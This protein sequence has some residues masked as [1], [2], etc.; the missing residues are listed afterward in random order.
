MLKSEFAKELQITKARIS[1]LIKEGLPV[2]KDGT[3][4]PEIAASWIAKY[5]SSGRGGHGLRPGAKPDIA[6]RAGEL[7]GKAG[8]AKQSP[9]DFAN[10]LL[11]PKKL[12]TFAKALMTRFN[13]GPREAYIAAELHGREV[14]AA[15]KD[16]D[17]YG[18][19]ADPTDKEWLK[20]LGDVDIEQLHAEVDE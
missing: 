20:V 1:Q 5:C 16:G 2:N 11:A 12:T 13:F 3:I 9:E 14:F 18:S 7:I 19:H 8:A 15:V 10:A 6:T 4:S 17:F